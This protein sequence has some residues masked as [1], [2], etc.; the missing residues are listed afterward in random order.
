MVYG[1]GAMA[2]G[3]LIGIVN[4]RLGGGRSVSLVSVVLAILIYG[5]LFVCNEVNSYNFLCYFSGF[6]IGSADS[7]QVTQLSIIFA[8]EY[9]DAAPAF[10]MLN[11]VKLLSMAIIVAIGSYL[12]SQASFRIY[13]LIALVATVVFQLIVFFTYKFNVPTKGKR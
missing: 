4:D 9:P 1:F 13:F 7:S 2:G 11:V 8:A 6:F 3:Q 5:S 12:T 10:A